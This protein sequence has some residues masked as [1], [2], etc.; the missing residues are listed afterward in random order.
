MELYHVEGTLNKGF[1]GQIT[2]MVSLEQPYTELDV[3]LTYDYAEL[4]YQDQ[5]MTRDDVIDVY[6][7]SDK[8][9]KYSEITPPV[10]KAF[11]N[12]SEEERRNHPLITPEIYEEFSAAAEA[13]RQTKPEITEDI[14][15]ETIEAIRIMSGVTISPEEARKILIYEID[16]KTEIHPLAMLNDEFIGCIHRQESDRH[17]IFRSD[18]ATEG[19]IPQERIEG[20]LKLTLLVFNIA[21]DNT[22]YTLTVS[23]K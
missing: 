3:H 16:L 8:R 11:F 23:G 4:R 20:V 15:Q 21:K 18:Y 10:L 14:L 6:L 12:M 7:P 22:R 1:V 9:T 19:C 13:H 17:M 5:K 2:Y